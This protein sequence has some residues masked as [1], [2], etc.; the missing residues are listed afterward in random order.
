M[1]FCYR[2]IKDFRDG[3]GSYRIGYAWSDDLLDWSRED[4]NSGIDVA[5]EGWDSMMIAYPYVIKT[6]DKILMFYNGNGFGKTGFGYAIL[7]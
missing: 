6:P 3:K 4:E 1:W 7:E 2:G 5:S